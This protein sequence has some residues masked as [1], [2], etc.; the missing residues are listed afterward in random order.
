MLSSILSSSSLLI[1]YPQQTDKVGN[2]FNLYFI[3]EETDHIM[4][5][6][7]TSENL[8]S[9]VKRRILLGEIRTIFLSFIE[10]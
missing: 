3:D 7:H 4:N 2:T 10:V 9:N 5:K 8:F 1:H 6:L